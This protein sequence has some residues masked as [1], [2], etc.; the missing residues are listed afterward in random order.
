MSETAILVIKQ[1][2]PHRA[3]RD[4]NAA[5]ASLL[6][7]VRLLG[8]TIVEESVDD[9]I[10]R[11]NPVGVSS[12]AWHY[13]NDADYWQTDCGRPFYLTDGTPAEHGFKFCP[14]CGNEIG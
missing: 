2:L 5:F 13:S 4:G 1:P 14:F 6:E 8:W 3:D 10:F 12:C 7:P 11:R 9:G